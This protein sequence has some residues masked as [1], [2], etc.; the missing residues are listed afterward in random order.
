MSRKMQLRRMLRRMK[1]SKI[2]CWTKRKAE[3]LKRLFG[4]CIFL[5][6][7]ARRTRSFRSIHSRCFSVKRSLPPSLSCSELKVVTT[8][9]MKRFRKKKKPMIRNRMKKSDQKGSR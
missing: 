9:P 8:T 2:G 4:D 5:R 1:R 7:A 3:R 6:G